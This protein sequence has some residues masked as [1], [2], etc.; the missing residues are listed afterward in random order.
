VGLVKKLHHSSNNPSKCSKNAVKIR[1]C[2][3]TTLQHSGG[4]DEI[5]G[6]ALQPPERETD[7]FL[8]ASFL[9]SSGLLN[10]HLCVVFGVKVQEKFATRWVPCWRGPRSTL[11]LKAAS[12]QNGK[13]C[14]VTTKRRQIRLCPHGTPFIGKL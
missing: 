4:R 1:T 13:S 14:Q 7:I 2:S 12:V 8:G 6:K 3:P 10:C 9:D 5:E 11:N